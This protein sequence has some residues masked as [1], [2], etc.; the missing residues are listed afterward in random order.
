MSEAKP[1]S[2]AQSPASSMDARSD[3]DSTVSSRE[4][5]PN[6][7]R[8]P[9]PAQEEQVRHFAAIASFP[10]IPGYE[11]LGEIGSGGMGVVYKA[12]QIAL[13][14]MV[15]LKMIKAKDGASEGELS[16]FRSEAEAVAR[17]QHPNIVQIYDVGEQDGRPY[18][19]LEFVDGGNLADHLRSGPPPLDAAALVETLARAV[20]AAHQQQII[21]RDIKPLNVL[22][23][24]SGVPKVTDFGLAK[25]L[26][27]DQVQTQT[28]AI[29]GTPAY[30]APEQAEGRIRAIGPATDTY[31]L[32]VILY[33]MLTGRVPFL[34]KSK[35]E[36]LDLVR[37]AEPTPPRQ[38][39]RKLPRDL[40]TICLKCLA[41]E[42]VER[43]TSALVLAQDLERF[44]GG[45][46]ILARRQGPVGRLW[47]KA[48]RHRLLTAAMLLATLATIGAGAIAIRYLQVRRLNDRKDQFSAALEALDD[49]PETLARIDG[50]A[51]ELE[52]LS[53][54]SAVEA[55]ARL[56]Q[57]LAD[58]L[59]VH[60]SQ[61]RL[62]TEDI[63]RADTALKALTARDARLGNSLASELQSR[64]G[65]LQLVL[66]LREPFA[67]PSSPNRAAAVFGA[68]KVEV[69]G[70]NLVH[71]PAPGPQPANRVVT[72]EPCV[73]D[74]E[75]KA[76]FRVATW[77]TASGLGL[78][79]NAG[80]RN[81]YAFLVRQ[82]SPGAPRS[83]SSEPDKQPTTSGRHADAGLTMTILRNGVRL[84]EQP[85]P[86]SA[87][88]GRLL[89]LE[90]KRLGN[91][92]VFY[93]NDAPPL[94]YQD[95]F[96]LGGAES[97]FFGLE[98]PSGVRLDSLQAYCQALPAA[99]SPLER[100]DDLYSRSQLD[101]A[102]AEYR[103]QA[104]ASTQAHI[105]QET[106]YKE[107][108]CRLDL[109]QDAEASRILNR[110]AAEPGDQWPALAAC[111][112]WVLLLRQERMDEAEA[113]FQNLRERYPFE[114]LAPLLPYDALDNLLWN[115]AREGVEWIDYSPELVRQAEQAVMIEEFLQRRI[116]FQIEARYQL[117]RVYWIA[118]REVEALETARK[119]IQNNRHWLQSNP[120]YAR[121][122]LEDYCW[123]LR[124][125][126]E[127]ER[128]LT[129]L[130]QWLF[131]PSG[132]IRE[133]HGS[134]APLLLERARLHVALKQP[135]DAA[136]DLR[137]FFDN[138][139]KEGHAYPD[140]ATAALMQ[141]FLQ[142]QRRGSAEEAQAEWKRGTYPAWRRDHP[143]APPDLPIRQRSLTGD[144]ENILLVALTGDLSD[145]DAK[146]LLTKL[147]Y[148]LMDDELVAKLINNLNFSPSVLRE[149][150]RTPQGHKLAR[151][152]AFR[153][154]PFPDYA[155]RPFF[156]WAVETMHTD[157][158][159]GNLSADQ[160]TLLEELVRQL[161]SAAV[162][163]RITR[164][165]G[166]G[167]LA[168][169]KG[170]AGQFGWSGA[171]AG[172][173][174]ALRGPLAY[175]GGKRLS[176]LGRPK[177][178]AL[179]LFRTALNDAP[180]DSRLRRLAQAELDRLSMSR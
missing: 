166:F 30:M 4:A 143:A 10:V 124:C 20:H 84:R 82:A 53:A 40:E 128:A 67:L 141:G 77:T 35:L 178:S 174:P 78:V 162:A 127:S 52:I 79:L 157:A 131:G 176:H 163:R 170:E 129:I 38:L 28:G 117:V 104:N 56:A 172:M 133:D 66:D 22:L 57:R 97:G 123:L 136:A 75:L 14:R 96:P 155:H 168:A 88:E 68:S 175:L 134:F 125:R 89:R 98:W 81:G 149:M 94:M 42:P 108:R 139:P 171:T 138:A 93:V 91:L 73:G 92:L 23:T 130:D 119:Q 16:R 109:K 120:D 169:W 151:Q 152:I 71:R 44:R 167:L 43:Y 12:R 159:P 105:R 54:E 1:T 87:L 160:R 50:L 100:G 110:L 7:T 80:P 106:A 39:Q 165:Q 27:A 85:L 154:L 70:P 153:D 61:P 107:A 132:E 6:A 102:I 144:G 18:L 46:P 41:K 72:G 33:E 122:L 179:A 112:L 158:M 47:R 29:F 115:S 36:T 8:L 140:I 5:D 59:R 64:L 48:R 63:A 11:I 126:G 173:D 156:L 51:G 49:H 31:A 121:A 3:C 69:D 13:K 111:Q 86:A 17:L 103:R 83:G 55:R 148:W 150:W 116:N 34:G 113:V 90:A 58:R 137:K 37:T 180:P 99:P 145:A 32:G 19:V 164:L 15:A 62:T 60:L 177:E 147:I 161:W 21:H 74:A 24:S 135:D 65:R 25:D 76:T 118:G 146:I 45:E 2:S 26:A 9:E 142:E 114:K 101:E 95:V